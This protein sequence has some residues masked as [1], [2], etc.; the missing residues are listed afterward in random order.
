[1]ARPFAMDP[2][3]EDGEKQGVVLFYDPPH[4]TPRLAAQRGCF[5]LHSSRY[6]VEE[7][8][9]PTAFEPFQILIPY[10]AVISIKR[11]LRQLGNRGASL[12]PGLDG[13][14]F[15]IVSMHNLEKRHSE[16]PL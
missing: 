4:I 5:T 10:S 9:W 14:A 6:P 8:A 15:D 2:V 11:T 3:G 12:F 16:F 13:I 1:M 7:V